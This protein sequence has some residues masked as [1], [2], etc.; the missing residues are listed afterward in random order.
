MDH[1]RAALPHAYPFLLIDRVIEVVRGQRAVAVKNLT[2]T[3]PLLDADGTLPPILLAEAMAQCAG[4]AV[5][6]VETGGKALVASFERFRS[7]RRVGAGEQLHVS[8]RVLRTFGAMAKVR[9]VVRVNGRA[10]AA[11]DVVLQLGS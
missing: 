3:D 10:R 9:A 6:G 2:H 7:R 4:V 1:S 5:L 11:C 8:A